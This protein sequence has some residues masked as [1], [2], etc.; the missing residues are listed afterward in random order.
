MAFER[1]HRDT[2]Y[3]VQSLSKDPAQKETAQQLFDAARMLEQ[4]ALEALGVKDPNE[5][6]LEAPRRATFIPERAQKYPLE[7]L[8]EDSKLLFRVAR[9]EARGFKHNYIGTEHVLLALLRFPETQTMLESYPGER[10]VDAKKVRAA[11][12]FIIGRGDRVVEG[13]I[14]M[15]P[16]VKTVLSLGAKEARGMELSTITPETILLGLIREGDGIAAGVLESFGV[17]LHKLRKHI[18]QKLPQ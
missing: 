1:K 11:V 6:Q 9:E 13:E 16:R 17:E 15:T 8:S 18:M 7:Y 14:G 5:A 3:W 2:E 12:D 10:V 4:K